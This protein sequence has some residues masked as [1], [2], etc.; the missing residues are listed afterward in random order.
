MID[1]GYSYIVFLENLTSRLDFL[2][3]LKVIRSSEDLEDSTY[4]P[5]TALKL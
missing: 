1:D 4:V 3:I 5:H 2:R